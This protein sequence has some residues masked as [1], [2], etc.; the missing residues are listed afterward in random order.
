MPTREIEVS[1]EDWEFVQNEVASGRYTSPEEVLKEAM[2]RAL[3]REGKQEDHEKWL[4]ENAEALAQE[5]AWI[6]KNGVPGAGI[7][8]T[9]PGLRGGR[10]VIRGLRVTVGDILGWLASGMSEAEILSDFPELTPADIRAAL[11]FAADRWDRIPVRDWI[12][13]LR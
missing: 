13:P 5:R 11:A 3:E 7:V 1:D 6:D 10:P 4:E 12:L 8:T 9:V 2:R